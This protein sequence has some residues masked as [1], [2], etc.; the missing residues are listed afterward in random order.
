M[1]VRIDVRETPRRRRREDERATPPTPVTLHAVH[2]HQRRIAK[3][4][5]LRERT[6][7][8]RGGVAFLRLLRLLFR[9]RAR[10][11]PDTVGGC[12]F[13]GF[14]TPRAVGG[15]A[16]TDARVGQLGESGE[17]RDGS[18]NLRHGE[19]QLHAREVSRG[20]PRDDGIESFGDPPLALGET[21]GADG[22]GEA[23]HRTRGARQ[24]RGDLRVGEQG[25][26]PAIE[27][28]GRRAKIAVP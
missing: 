21:D 18:T 14:E 16:A 15:A 2:L 1:A 12:A 20:G 25:L 9:I 22:G 4:D 3:H 26:V 19:V 23:R 8:L 24:S 7:L 27:R 6:N 5:N 11:I 13:A 28:I 17:V 10:L